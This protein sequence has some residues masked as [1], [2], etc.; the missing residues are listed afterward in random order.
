MYRKIFITYLLFFCCLIGVDGQTNKYNIKLTIHNLNDKVLYLKGY[1][2][3][4]CF[5]ADSA[6][7][8][9]N[10]VTFKT[11]LAPGYYDIVNQND[12]TY[13]GVIVNESRHFSI[14][15]DTN[16]STV[17]ISNST[18]NEF[19]FNFLN[20]LVN[21]SEENQMLITHNY[22]TQLPTNVVMQMMAFDYYA[23]NSQ[24]PYSDHYFD[25]VPLKDPMLRFPMTH[26]FISQ[27]FNENITDK[28]AS[29]QLKKIDLFYAHC[30]VKSE[31]GQYYLKWLLKH[32]LTDFNPEWDMVFV[33]L[34]EK[35]FEPNGCRF[36]TETNA[37]IM[38]KNVI[39]K[40]R[41]LNGNTIP[42]LQITG[43]DGK[44]ESTENP[45]HKYTLIW[46][47]DPDCDDCLVETPAL[48]QY[49]AENAEKYDFEVFAVALTEDVERWKNTVNEMQLTWINSCE[50]D[51]TTNYDFKDY[52]N[53]LTTPASF[54]I[55]QNHKIILQ[56]ITLEKLQNFFENHE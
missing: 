13:W 21:E 43:N 44:V 56:Q 3:E 22:I 46:F 33:Y 10:S 12:D 6:K 37:R 42:F 20:Q 16:Y 41:T 24:L 5:L 55:D 7:V 50:G 35:Y 32:Y 54:L 47:W 19:F 38:Q 36:L 48:Q 28:S 15:S 8:K 25:S 52:F 1:C 23:R 53:I 27:F 4:E 9:K 26:S 39:R 31:I 11:Q 17:L 49:Y 14:V 30:D 29:A 34:Y 45:Q 51:G 18:E 40:K 2:G